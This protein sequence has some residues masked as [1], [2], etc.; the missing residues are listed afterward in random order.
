M[1]LIWLILFVLLVETNFTALAQDR[2]ELSIVLTN[3]SPNVDAG[4]DQTITIADSAFLD[5]AVT[6]DGLPAYQGR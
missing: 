1:A 2:T 5:G 6:D 4:L 3:L